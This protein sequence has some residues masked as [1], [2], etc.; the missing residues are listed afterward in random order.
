MKKKQQ[1]EKEINSDKNQ[2]L[3]IFF[4]LGKNKKLFYLLFFFSYFTSKIPTIIDQKLSM[5]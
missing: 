2:K 3:Q 5:L 4:R 1:E